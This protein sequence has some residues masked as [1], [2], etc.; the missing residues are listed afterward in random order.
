MEC[1]SDAERGLQAPVPLVSAGGPEELLAPDGALLPDR[2]LVPDQSLEPVAALE[3]GP[4][5]LASFSPLTILLG[6]EKRPFLRREQ[7][8][9]G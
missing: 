1:E 5:R 8:A 2:V 7:A 4:A 6:A 3:P 9:E